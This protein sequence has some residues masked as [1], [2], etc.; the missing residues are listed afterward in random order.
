METMRKFGDVFEHVVR[1]MAKTFTSQKYNFAPT[2]FLLI[3]GGPTVGLTVLL[4][5][6]KQ[7]GA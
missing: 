1:G 2:A 6:D 5:F 7:K 4:L 3:N